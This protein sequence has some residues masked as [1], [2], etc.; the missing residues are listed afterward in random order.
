MPNPEITGT[1]KKSI[2]KIK[3]NLLKWPLPPSLKKSAS[4][5]VRTSTTA[6]FSTVQS[7]PSVLSRNGPIVE[8]GY[9]K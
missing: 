4:D 3:K 8:V 5:L 6:T 9:G 2:E 7:T 1:L